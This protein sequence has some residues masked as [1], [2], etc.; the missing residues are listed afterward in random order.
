MGKAEPWKKQEGTCEVNCPSAARLDRL[1]SVD[2]GCAR[3]SKP[4]ERVGGQYFLSGRSVGKRADGGCYVR[5]NGH[6]KNRNAWEQGSG[7]AHHVQLVFTKS[8]R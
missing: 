7:S 4:A 2:F 5:G 1:D 8:N 3:L 6:V